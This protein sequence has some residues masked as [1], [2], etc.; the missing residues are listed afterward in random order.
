[1]KQPKD[2]L[3]NTSPVMVAMETEVDFDPDHPAA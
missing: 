2:K 3:F 1:M